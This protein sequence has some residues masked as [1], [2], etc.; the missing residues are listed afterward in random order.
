[1]ARAKKSETISMA[2]TTGAEI[3]AWIPQ[4]SSAKW[5]GMCHTAHSSATYKV[6]FIGWYRSCQ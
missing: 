3:S 4:P 5:S 2:N 1:M 6:S